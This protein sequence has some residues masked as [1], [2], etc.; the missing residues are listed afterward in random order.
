VSTPGEAAP[1][2][3]LWVASK[4]EWRGGI[5]NVVARGTRAL[6]ALGH[7]VHAAG[8]APDGDPGPLSG[9]T[10]HAWRLRRFMVALLADLVPLL[11]SLRRVVV[12]FDSA[13]PL[14]DVICGLRWL[15]RWGDRTPL[16]GVSAHSWRPF[17]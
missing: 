4:L 17:S 16:V 8:P 2:R 9:V 5:G 1:L 14:G 15:R 10:A 11:R 7:Q 3:I 12:L 6:A 13:L